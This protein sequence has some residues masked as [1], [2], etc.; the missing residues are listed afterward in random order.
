MKSR[1]IK[2]FQYNKMAFILTVTLFISL[3]LFSQ[4]HAQGRR[5]HP[6]RMY[7]PRVD[8]RSQNYVRVDVGSKRYFYRNGSFYRRTRWGFNVIAAPIGARIRVLPYG[9][10]TYRF[11]GLD[12]FYYNGIYYNYLPDQNVYVVVQKPANTDNNS[13]LKLDQVKLYNGSV[14]Y[15]IF[16]GATDSTITL[17]VGNQD[18]DI[19]ISN[20]ISINF[21]PSI[22]DS[23]QQ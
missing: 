22:S 15:G 8:H 14:M 23:T 20:I 9:F 2:I 10:V 16:Q 18:Q 4:S 7:Q 17:R 13:N 21:A 12:Y 11:G 19:N 1:I 5:N 6:E 3:S